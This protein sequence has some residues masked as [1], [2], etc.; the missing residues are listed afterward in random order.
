MGVGEMSEPSVPETFNLADIW[1]AAA[2]R[3]GDRP[4]VICGDRRLTYV[5]LEA[6]ANRL[7]DHLLGRGVEAGEHRGRSGE[8]GREGGGGGV[9][10]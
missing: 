4:A 1:E 2:D 10:G 6:R 7:A 9:A 8:S 3:C 5:D